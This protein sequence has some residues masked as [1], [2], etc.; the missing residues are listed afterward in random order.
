M[1]SNKLFCAS[2]PPKGY[3]LKS[4]L[5]MGIDEARIVTFDRHK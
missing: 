4:N 3:K 2:P 5:Q 1:V